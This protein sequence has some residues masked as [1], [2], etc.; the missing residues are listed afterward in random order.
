MRFTKKPSKL[1]LTLLLPLA[2]LALIAAGCGS[3][4]DD[5]TTAAAAP[6]ESATTAEAADD[7]GSEQGDAGG[8]QKQKPKRDGTTISTS[9]SQFGE[10]LFGA[11]DRAIYTFDKETSSESQC[12]GDCA[13]DWPPVLTEGAPQADG[14]VAEGKLGTTKRDD[15]ATQVTYEGQPLYYY[16]ND[17]AGVVGC[18]DVPGFGGLWLA[19]DSSGAAV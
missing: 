14:D 8:E 4:D 6:A 19:I 16:H 5:D 11:G 3:D 2:A 15:G 13:V 7:A 17:P 18:H 12:H 10:V 9:D 1:V